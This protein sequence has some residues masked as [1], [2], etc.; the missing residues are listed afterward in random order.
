MPVVTW[1]A[2]LLLT[3]CA[4]AAQEG[5][6]SALVAD[7]ETPFEI[8]K[9]PHD[10]PGEIAFTAEWSAE[11]RQSLRIDPG[12]AA[13]LD[14]LQLRDWR[15][16][17]VLRVHVNNPSDKTIPVAF[18][19]QDRNKSFPDRHQNG[20]GVP[21]GETTVDIDIA[22][23]LWRGEENLPYLGP[24]KTPIDIGSITRV[25]FA[26]QGSGP[27]FVDWIEVVRTKQIEAQGAYA[28]DFGKAGTQFMGQFI[29][30]PNNMDY[31]ESRGYG[32]IG[33]W[34]ST[35]NRPMSFPTPML[36]KGA[37]FENG[38]RVDLSGGDYL[39][40]IAFE[41][42]GFWDG[43]WSSYSR[44]VLKNN[45]SPVHEHAFSPDGI[46]F[47]FQ[48]TE[49]TDLRNLARDLIRPAHAVSTFR[50][51][52]AEGGNTFTLEIENPRGYPLRV[53]GLILVPDTEEG[54]SFLRDHEALQ[55]K[56]VTRTYAAED[57]ARRGEN[58]GREQPAVDLVCE[59]LPPGAMMYPRDWPVHATGAKPK[60]QYSA[61]GQVVTVHLGLY[62]RRPLTVSV[63]A[64]PWR[65]AGEL[66][67][68]R[69]SYGR[70]MPQ[71]HY[72]VGSTWLEVNHY[73]PESQFK[74]GPDLSRS[75]LVECDI[76]ADAVP[77]VYEG[78]VRITGDGS[79]LQVPLR[80]TVVAVELPSIPIGVGL[81]RNAL[82]FDPN[83]TGDDLW[84]SLQES[85]L[86]EQGR[87]GLNVISGGEGIAYDVT[88]DGS[89]S[90]DTA[91]RY[92]KM[93]VDKGLDRAVV[94]Y[95][96][97]LGRLSS[98]G[99]GAG[100]RTDFPAFRANLEQ[101]EQTHRLPPTFV[102]AYDEPRNEEMMRNTAATIRPATE[103]GLRTIG[104][105]SAHWGNAGWE[106]L[107][108]ATYA[109]ALSGHDAETIRKLK[110]GGKHP[111]IYGGV[112]R[113]ALGLQLW[114]QIRL[115]VE[116]RM[117][118][119]GFF[120]QGFA[121]HNLDGREP[122][123]ACFAV[124]RNFGVLKTPLWLGTREGLLDLRVRLALER[125]CPEDDPILGLWPEE[126]YLQDAGQWPDERL[127]DVRTAY[128]K[129]IR[130][131]TR[132]K[133]QDTSP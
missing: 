8:N 17:T 30:V 95:G 121:F 133:E 76:P 114:R 109:P 88:P 22:G 75:L 86:A 49:I 24:T 31:A 28:F 116:G 111:W 3:T 106:E 39:G 41:R 48:D 38:F 11:G 96:G 129:R 100:F 15:G 118:W 5:E 123:Y 60:D 91:V 29:G 57:K 67:A 117:C 66:P 102:N 37:G 18:E 84:W 68:P 46:Q 65:G 99:G 43:E 115:G 87:A 85:V 1:S 33:G 83:T 56:T 51:A 112:G 128:L 55:D 132:N 16:Y 2:V 79:V 10:H 25:L 110:A 45:G 27:L 107:I 98:L 19:L 36:G 70:Y 47:L 108:D 62:A 26:N 80:I 54:R 64:D 9:W 44:A 101:F 103:A 32:M 127:D 71:R 6:P 94:C 92:V 34:A 125:L 21:P 59:P 93:A 7:F 23:A 82:P 69:I 120:A 90:G 119:I 74:A 130:E 122:A 105:T 40:W 53:A 81:F 4:A 35:L 78:T 104:W 72:A 97:F 52:A 12:L 61:R 131:L 73:R 42:G 50:F 77:G 63:T 58:S 126:G 124:H 13:A 89:V 20:F 14:S 113:Y